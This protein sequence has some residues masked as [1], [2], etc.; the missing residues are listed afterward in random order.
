MNFDTSSRR[1][2][3]GVST[4]AKTHHKRRRPGPPCRRSTTAMHH[5]NYH[6]PT[7]PG[8][9]LKAAQAKNAKAGAQHR[10]WGRA[11][12]TVCA[13]LLLLLLAA[14]SPA[15]GV[16]AAWSRHRQAH[17]AEPGARLPRSNQTTAV[18]PAPPPQERPTPGTLQTRARAWLDNQTRPHGPVAAWDTSGET[19][20]ARVFQG[21]ATFNEDLNACVFSVAFGAR[22]SPA[23]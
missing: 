22:L 17:G 18:A 13:L 1:L 12:S 20:L 4:A 19:D 10:A 3:L 21:A 7:M 6:H 15:S 5:G 23:A 14:P 2:E 9:M 16:D 8:S 11:F